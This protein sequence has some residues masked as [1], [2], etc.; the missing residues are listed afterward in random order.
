M[1]INPIIDTNAVMTPK[2]TRS[3]AIRSTEFGYGI[4]VII[5]RLGDRQPT[6]D[7]GGDR[8]ISVI[9]VNELSV[10]SG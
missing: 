1:I 4:I 10:K 5:E 3:L 2:P 8:S 7:G 9:S 6:G